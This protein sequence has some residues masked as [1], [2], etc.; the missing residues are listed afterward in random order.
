MHQLHGWLCANGYLRRAYAQHDWTTHQ[1][2]GFKRLAADG[3][4]G[5]EIAKA[6]GRSETSVRSFASARKIRIGSKHRWKPGER[7]GVDRL[8][9][10][11]IETMMR[12]LGVSRGAALSQIVHSVERLRARQKSERITD[13][14]GMRTENQ[15][16]PKGRA[17]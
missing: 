13:L 17:A 3:R 11:T 1:I 6:I 8:V 7:R 15:A 14:G 4:S 9:E 5:P 16:R 10:R 12:E 2:A